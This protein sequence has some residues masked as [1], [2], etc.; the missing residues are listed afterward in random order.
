LYSGI[1][2]ITMGCSAN[3]P[4][5]LPITSRNSLGIKMREMISN[6]NHVCES[7]ISSVKRRQIFTKLDSLIRDLEIVQHITMCDRILLTELSEPFAF[8]SNIMTSPHN[9]GNDNPNSFGTLFPRSLHRE[10]IE[11]YFILCEIIFHHLIQQSI[12]KYF[13]EII[14]LM[15]QHKWSFK[16]MSFINSWIVDY[17]ANERNTLNTSNILCTRCLNP[18]VNKHKENSTY[19][20]SLSTIF[21]CLQLMGCPVGVYERLFLIENKLV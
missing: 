12:N 10:E 7:K 19:K 20:T 17:I 13:L 15:H 4:I 9:L 3:T 21:E 8:R 2:N 5:Q 14:K 11:L 18:Q 1:I 16:S 6:I